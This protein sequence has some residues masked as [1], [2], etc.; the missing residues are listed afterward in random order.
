MCKAM[1]KSPLLLFVQKEKHQRRIDF[2]LSA[3]M[4]TIPREQGG[5]EKWRV[6]W[7]CLLSRVTGKKSTKIKLNG[8]GS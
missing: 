6:G 1:S 4:E 5:K 2:F 8:Y 7:F 3:L